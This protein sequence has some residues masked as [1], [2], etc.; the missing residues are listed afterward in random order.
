MKYT[1]D[2]FVRDLAEPYAWP[3][4]YPRFFV[5]SDGAA[6]SYKAAQQHRQT[7]RRSIRTNSEDGWRV[8]A[9]AINWE[10]PDL[11]CDHTGEPI[12][13]AYESNA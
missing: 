3:G 2:Q 5:C 7:I 11:I 12:Q 8:V 4:G 9:C 10:E 1:A 6:L 13:S